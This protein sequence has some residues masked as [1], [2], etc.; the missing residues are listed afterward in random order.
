MRTGTFSALIKYL[1]T[2]LQNAHRPAA[3]LAQRAT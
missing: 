1:T 2:C 3:G